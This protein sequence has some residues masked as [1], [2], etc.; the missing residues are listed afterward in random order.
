MNFEKNNIKNLAA[1]QM[2]K[3]QNDLT[4]NIQENKAIIDHMSV[5]SESQ[6]HKNKQPSYNKKPTENSNRII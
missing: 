4:K 6:L 1:Y 2:Q 5:Y 3:C